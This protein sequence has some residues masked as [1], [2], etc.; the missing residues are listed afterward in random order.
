MQ[1]V[2]AARRQGAMPR[3]AARCALSLT[4]AIC[5]V[6]GQPRRAHAISLAEEGDGDAVGGEVV[7][8]WVS[9]V[10]FQGVN[11]ALRAAT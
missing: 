6:P 1:G 4:E 10:G 3:R 2:L 7:V 5:P 9:E 11:G 8:P